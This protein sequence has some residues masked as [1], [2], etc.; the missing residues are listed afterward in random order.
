M[1]QLRRYRLSTLNVNNLSFSYDHS[2]SRDRQRKALDNISFEAGPGESIGI[3]GANGAG[4]TT[5]LKLLVGLYT[6]FEGSIN[7]GETAVSKKTLT[8]IRRKIGYVFQDSDS[9]LFM[10]R[11]Y[12]DIAFGPRN[13]G[14]SADE[15]KAR[16]EKAMELTGSAYLRDKQIH[17]L[18][19]GEKKLVSIAT[20]LSLD[21]DV[22]IMD[23]PSNALDPGNRRRLINV[24]N[25]LNCTKLIATHDLDMIWDT[26]ERS[27][28]ISEGKIAADGSTKELLTDKKLLESNHLELPLSAKLYL[29]ESASCSV[30]ASGSVS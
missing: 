16:T 17:K 26:C 3:I 27:I 8:E 6:D 19:G 24:L 22:M 12:D 11:V 23:E 20:V 2:Q 5:L 4:K 1:K 21:P 15:V 10:M 7:I 25:S 14:Y 30:S 13:Y 29:L 18:S 9:Q 28:L